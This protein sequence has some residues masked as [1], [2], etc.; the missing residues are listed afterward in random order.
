LFDAGQT[1]LIQY[2]V[3]KAGS[4]YTIP[5][6]VTHIGYQAFVDSIGLTRAHYPALAT[7]A[8]VVST[9]QLRNMGTIGGN[10]CVDTRC[11]YYNQGESWREALT[12]CMKKDGEICW[13]APGSPRCWAV[14][15]SDTAPVMIALKAQ[16]RLL[17]PQG[18]RTIPAQALY[19]NDGIEYLQKLPSEIVVDI[20]LPDASGVTM[21]YQKLRR[22]SAFD[23]PIMAAAVALRLEEDG[24]CREANIVLGAV[25]SYPIKANEAEAVLVGQKITEEV[26][27]EAAKIAFKPAK[28]LD[29]TDMGHPYRKQMARVYVARAL[30][31]AAGLKEV[32]IDHTPSQPI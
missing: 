25:A 22:R 11:T 6:T 15:S 14:S 16:V 29:N 18:E 12:Y 13:V 19:N 9:P 31:E 10:L 1:T 23:F 30:R 28:P 8:G 20:S 2:P 32:K 3:A 24:T 5:G 21:S 27:Q 7:A 26:I 4:D 17:G